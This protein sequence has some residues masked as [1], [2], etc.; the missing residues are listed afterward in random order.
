MELER[1]GPFHNDKGELEGQVACWGCLRRAEDGERCSAR[2]GI[3]EAVLTRL[4]RA[5]QSQA[6]ESLRRSKLQ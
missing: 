1:A 3:L 2:R 5:S 4:D 6:T